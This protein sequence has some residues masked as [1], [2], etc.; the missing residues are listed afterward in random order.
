MK[1]LNYDQFIE[2]LQ[3]IYGKDIYPKR[4]NNYPNSVFFYKVKHPTTYDQE[5]GIYTGITA[6]FIY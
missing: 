2:E 1:E 3:K 6:W 5:I 4:W